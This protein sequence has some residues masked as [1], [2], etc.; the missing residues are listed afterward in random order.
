MMKTMKCNGSYRMT[1]DHALCAWLEGFDPRSQ[2]LCS[3]CYFFLS[4]KGKVISLVI[5]CDRKMLRGSRSDFMGLSGDNLVG[6]NGW[7]CL[8][9]NSTFEGCWRQWKLEGEVWLGGSESL[10]ICHW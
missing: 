3:C 9:M 8:L 1:G 4:P 10:W 2:M 5:W 7:F 6:P